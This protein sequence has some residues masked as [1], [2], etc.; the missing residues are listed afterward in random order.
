MSDVWL[1]EFRLGDA[2]FILVHEGVDVWMQ[3]ICPWC[4]GRD[5]D[6]QYNHPVRCENYCR[7]CNTI[8]CRTRYALVV[9]VA[10]DDIDAGVS[11]WVRG[12][13]EINENIDIEVIV[14]D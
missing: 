4:R 14:H 5:L 12:W 6:A 2:L 7:D 3:V 8:L 9:E 1:Q 11:E 13:A 10:Y